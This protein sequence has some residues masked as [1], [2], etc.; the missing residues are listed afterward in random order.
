M[1][2]EVHITP[3]GA[4]IALAFTG[5]MV[6]LLWWMLHPPKPVPQVAARAKWAVGAIRRILVPTVGMPYSERGVE[7]ACRLGQEQKAEIILVYV[8]E[9]PRTLSLSTPLPEVEA[10]ATEIL[11]QANDIVSSHGLRASARIERAREASEGIIRAARDNEVNLIVVGV[12][13]EVSPMSE[14]L[15]RTTDVLL[16]RAPCEVIIDKLPE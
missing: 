6:G 7:L 15:G 5:L 8:I 12:R 16:R 3:L 2:P 9:V 13:P 4:L 14:L 1:N 11:N 10:K